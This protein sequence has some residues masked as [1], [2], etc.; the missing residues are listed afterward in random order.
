M[1]DA[2]SLLDEFI[3]GQNPQGNRGNAFLTAEEIAAHIALD[4]AAIEEARA[5]CLAAIVGL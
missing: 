5:S 2:K 4:T 3:G 1:F